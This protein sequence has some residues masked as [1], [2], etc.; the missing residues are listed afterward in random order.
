MFKSQSINSDDS[1]FLREV[2]E[3]YQKPGGSTGRRFPVKSPELDHAEL[4]LLRVVGR[5][6]APIV[7]A[8]DIQ[9]DASDEQLDGSSRSG[10]TMEVHIGSWK[11][12]RVAV[13]YIRRSHHGESYRRAMVNRNFE[14]QL[15]SKPSLRS[16]RN[17]T[18]LLAI[19]FNTDIEASQPNKPEIPVLRPGLVVELAPEPYPDLRLFFETSRNPAWPAS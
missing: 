10:A 17:V 3:A 19:C 6:K 15:M 4:G 1:S 9:R 7:T 13:K 2:A 18:K 12:Q 14:L 16:H 11:G 8:H 5:N